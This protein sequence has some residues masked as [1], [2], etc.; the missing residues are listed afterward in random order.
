MDSRIREKARK[1][2]MLLL[3]VDGVLTDGTFA[4][5]GEDEI[6]RF[7][8]RDG[9]G[10]VLARRAGLKLGLISGRSSAA[11]VHR[12]QELSID[13]VRLG[14]SDKITAYR[15][16]L[17]E[18][19]LAEEQVACM[20]DDL[21]DLPLLLRG[22]LSAAPADAHVEVRSRV[23]Y[24]TRA[25]GGFGAVREVVDLILSAKGVLPELIEEYLR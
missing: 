11:V 21:P 10:L 22:G 20:G 8:S 24:V 9:I 6:K 17:A 25:R 19:G 14:A 13:F 18:A 15:E 5:Q 1:V 2:E 16:A 3:D 7:H 23:D 4:R 12:A